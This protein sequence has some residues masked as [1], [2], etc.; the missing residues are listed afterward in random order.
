MTEASKTA[1]NMLINGGIGNHKLSNAASVHTG[2][3]EEKELSVFRD[4]LI[5]KNGCLIM[6]LEGQGYYG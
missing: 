2:E 6:K 3:E 4:F 5:T 1:I